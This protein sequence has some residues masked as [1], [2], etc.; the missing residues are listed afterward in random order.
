MSAFV[1]VV[2]KF[3]H[4]PPPRET[5]G[6][7]YSVWSDTSMCADCTLLCKVYHSVRQMQWNAEVIRQ[8]WG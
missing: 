1:Q 8:A 4:P 2:T 3:P 5:C 7:R 6:S